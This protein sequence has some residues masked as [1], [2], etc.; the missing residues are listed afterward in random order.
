[1]VIDDNSEIHSKQMKEI[2]KDDVVKLLGN[3][4]VVK[5][6][7]VV[8]PNTK[9]YKIKTHNGIEFESTYNHINLVN[10]NNQQIEVQTQHLMIGDQIAFLERSF[11]NKFKCE[12]SDSKFDTYEFGKI[13]GM[14]IGD[15]HFSKSNTIS[16]CLNYN[17]KH[18]LKSFLD[19]YL[20]KFKL[21]ISEYRST[22][23]IGE[24]APVYTI[25]MGDDCSLSEKQEFFNA[26]SFFINGRTAHDKKLSTKTINM[27]EEFRYGIIDG[28]EET[29][30]GNSNRIYSVNKNLIDSFALVLTSVGLSYNIDTDQRKKTKNGKLSDNPIYCIRYYAKNKSKYLDMFTRDKNKQLI[31]F[32]ITSIEESNYDKDVHCFEII[33]SDDK[34]FTLSNG[35]YTHNCR[36]TSNLSDLTKKKESLGFINSIGGTSLKIG[37]L[38]VNTINMARI[39]LESKYQQDAKGSFMNLLRKRAILSLQVL[40]VIRSIIKRN[41]DKGLL[42]IYQYKILE[43]EN[44]YNTLGVAAMYDAL[45]ILGMIE[46][47]DFGNKFYTREGEKFSIEIL[48]EL[49]KIKDEFTAGKPYLVNIEAV[50]AEK[51]AVTLC[52]KDKLLYGMT[53]VSKN[54]YANQ[55]IS[56]TDKCTMTEKIKL[57]SMLDKLVGGKRLPPCMVTCSI[58]KLRKLLEV[59]KAIFPKA[60]S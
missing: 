49:N 27:T 23:G 1:M 2:E 35:I 48:Q 52:R 46:T 55:W 56:L 50:P 19:E 41:I 6:R 47:D 58:K 51:A 14:L 21:K 7:K 40:D 25:R 3:G 54:I 11:N 9:M 42:P 12:Y 57:S 18:H 17:T 37:S 15:G 26:I 36:L 31:F 32:K 29:D 45:D 44:Q 10:R 8:L 16:F 4:K 30:G 20:S 24:D 13:I 34:Y 60:E 39:A 38:Q 53:N 33:D 43:L 59:R 5:G 22:T 28:Y